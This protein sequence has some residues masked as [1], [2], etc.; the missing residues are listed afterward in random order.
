MLDDLKRGFISRFDEAARYAVRKAYLGP[1]TLVHWFHPGRADA[2]LLGR[3]WTL[4]V[5]RRN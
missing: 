1:T 3:V 5:E 2:N 4:T